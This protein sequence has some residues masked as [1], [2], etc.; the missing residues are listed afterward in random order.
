MACARPRQR[1]RLGISKRRCALAWF[2]SGCVGLA[3]RTVLDYEINTA[4][5]ESL[6][7]VEKR[8][9]IETGQESENIQV[10]GHMSARAMTLQKVCSIEELEDLAHRMEAQIEKER[11]EK[12]AKLVEAPAVVNG[13]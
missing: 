12:Q 10:T 11:L 9:A 2:A 5:I 3:A 6:N 7:S 4:L 1:S 13:K 8:A